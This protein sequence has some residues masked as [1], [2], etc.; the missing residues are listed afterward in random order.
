MHYQEMNDKVKYNRQFQKYVSW[1]SKQIFPSYWYLSQKSK[2]KRN[3]KTFDQKKVT[4]TR[5]EQTYR[6]IR[7]KLASRYVWS[8][9]IHKHINKP[10][11]IDDINLSTLR[12]KMIL[13]ICSIHQNVM[14]W[15]NE[16]TIDFRSLFS[17]YDLPASHILPESSH[18]LQ[19]APSSF[20]WSKFN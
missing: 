12:E 17:E 9:I 11:L 6:D 16:I 4:R 19:E 14:T 3:R 20:N 7:I 13:P 10:A 15:I 1:F 5:L 18:I 2:I 8:K